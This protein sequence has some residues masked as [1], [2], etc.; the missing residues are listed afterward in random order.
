M[1][2][3]RLVLPLSV[4]GLTLPLTNGVAWGGHAHAAADPPRVV[5]EVDLQRYKGRWYEIARY[6]NRFQDQCVGDVTATYRLLED[7]DVEVENRCR[8]ADGDWDV[9]TGVARRTDDPTNAKLEV[10]FAPLILSFLPAVWGDYW[11]IGLA[12]DY[13]WAVV[14]DP[15][16]EYLWI[17]SRT[18]QI[19][20]ADRAR[21]VEIIRQN[22]FDPNRL[23]E[24]PQ[25][26]RG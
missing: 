4:L 24:T 25:P 19:A 21:A 26:G 9:A 3:R 11:V 6:P 2:L 20:P 5:P 22:G 15:S 14:G 23:V 12:P 7:G 16:R 17:L 1:K 8:T 13:S 18:P 10:R